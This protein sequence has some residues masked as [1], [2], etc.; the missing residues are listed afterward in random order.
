MGRFYGKRRPLPTQPQ[1][2][3]LP[4]GATTTTSAGAASAG[5]GCGD[6]EGGGGTPVGTPPPPLPEVVANALQSGQRLTR[7]CDEWHQGKQGQLL[8][9]RGTGAAHAQQ[10]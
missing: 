8:A 7:L 3:D 10:K 4:E 2:P 5:G 9:A 6:F 1:Q